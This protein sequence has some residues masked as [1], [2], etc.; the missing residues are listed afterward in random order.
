MVNQ[1]YAQMQL[2]SNEPFRRQ[3]IDDS[4]YHVYTV[5]DKRKLNIKKDKKFT[6]LRITLTCIKVRCKLKGR[7]SRGCSVG[8][9]LDPR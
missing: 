9:N 4:K 6:R 3:V 8:R 7:A 1:W 2:V 5:S